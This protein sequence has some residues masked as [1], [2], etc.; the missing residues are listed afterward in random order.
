MRIFHTQLTDTDKGYVI[1]K[2]CQL[3]EELEWNNIKQNL[4]FAHYII[5]ATIDFLLKYND[6]DSL[7]G[8]LL[9]ANLF[10]SWEDR[11]LMMR[12]F[13]WRWWDKSTDWWTLATAESAL[14]QLINKY[15]AA[16]ILLL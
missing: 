9:F 8:K 16:F 2:A 14:R 11:N 7:P 13:V 4:E 5:E 15:A 6:D 12:V 10:R 1:E 3:L